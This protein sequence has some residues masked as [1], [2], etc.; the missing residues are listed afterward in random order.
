MLNKLGFGGEIGD[1]IDLTLMVPDG[2]GFL[3]EKFEK[4]YT[5]T[6]ILCDQYLYQMRWR[7]ETPVY[8]DLPAAIVSDQET[9]EA[10]GMYITKCY[11]V[12]GKEFTPQK[13]Y[14]LNF[15]SSSAFAGIYDNLLDFQS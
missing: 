13:I 1:T 8:S 6:G 15:D 14:D 2:T 3:G 12:F 9:I 5:L 11:Y 10:G 4:S 7:E